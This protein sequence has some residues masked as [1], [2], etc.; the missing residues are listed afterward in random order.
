M[1]VHT[2]IITGISLLRT[3]EHLYSPSHT[4]AH[5]HT[6]ADMRVS[7]HRRTLGS[8]FRSWIPSSREKSMIFK[9]MSNWVMCMCVYVHVCVKMC[10]IYVFVRICMQKTV[11]VEAFICLKRVDAGMESSV[12]KSARD[13]RPRGWC[14]L[15]QEVNRN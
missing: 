7:E 11:S 8:S 12:M 3:Q 1:H 10:Y 13:E 6:C 15:L 9:L 2:C 4:H 5:I 14:S